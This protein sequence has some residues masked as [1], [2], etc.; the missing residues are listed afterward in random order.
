MKE[1]VFVFIDGDYTIRDNGDTVMGPSAHKAMYL[2]W[3][4]ERRCGRML[5]TAES[6]SFIS[7]LAAASMN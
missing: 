4:H 6:A 1:K 5:S 3:A 2:L 7:P